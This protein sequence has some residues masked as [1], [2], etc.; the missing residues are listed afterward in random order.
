MHDFADVLADIGSNSDQCVSLIGKEQ[1]SEIAALRS[2][3]DTLQRRLAEREEKVA[4]LER[5]KARL[6]KCLDQVGEVLNGI[7]TGILRSLPKGHSPAWDALRR[8]NADSNLPTKVQSL[9][10]FSQA[11]TGETNTSRLLR[12]SLRGHVEF[13]TRL[14]TTPE[15][16]TLFLVSP[17]SGGTLLPETTREL[18]LEQ[19]AR[20]SQLLENANS[21]DIDAFGS[22]R[23]VL[24]LD[25]DPNRRI[26]GIRDLIHGNEVKSEDLEVLLLQEVMLTSTLRRYAKSLRTSV[27][28]SAAIAGKALGESPTRVR[29]ELLDTLI[30]KLV[31][32]NV[33]LRTDNSLD[34]AWERWGA[35][36]YFAVTGIRNR[37]V[38]L[39]NVRAAIEE[40]ALTG[41]GCTVRRP[42][43]NSGR[44]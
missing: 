23:E 11:S 20:T 10:E 6:T 44:K 22:I 14:A 43:R 16:Q 37:T 2:Q 29:P 39:E 8:I 7:I 41:A 27:R 40:A 42:H 24:D 3:I 13:L 19:A 4:L 12:A 32:Q 15:L 35:D 28:D 31:L 18:L 38:E 17:T 5:S 21:A 34:T 33:Q 9:F 26:D 25:I 1:L 36:L 30:K